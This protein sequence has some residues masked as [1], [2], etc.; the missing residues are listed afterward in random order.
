MKQLLISL[1]LF[2]QPVMGQVSEP[3][4]ELDIPTLRV[5]VHP[6]RV[7]GDVRAKPSGD[8]R[9]DLQGSYILLEGGGV[10]SMADWVLGGINKN[11]FGVGSSD[12]EARLFLGNVGRAMLGIDEKMTIERSRVTLFPGDMVGLKFKGMEAD[13][14]ASHFGY[15][16]RIA[17][18]PP[19]NRGMYNF[20]G[21][22]TEDPNGSVAMKKARFNLKQD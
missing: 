20:S 11:R 21:A 1:F 12:Y 5:P 9:L 4:A 14:L 7:I 13:V 3:D 19:A 10:V 18:G 16:G 17:Q 8:L 2:G 6:K 22:L 15:Q